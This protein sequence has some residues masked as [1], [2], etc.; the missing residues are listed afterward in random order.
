MSVTRIQKFDQSANDIKMKI[1][2]ESSVGDIPKIIL[3]KAAQFLNWVLA[4]NQTELELNMSE[5]LTVGKVSLSMDK[6]KKSAPLKSLG[7]AFDKL[8]FE[9]H[10]K[11]FNMMQTGPVE[12]IVR[13]IPKPKAS[14]KSAA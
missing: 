14:K 13:A 9:D 4:P 11:L 7:I 12:V 2:V 10:S 6:P 5:Q 3:E 8:S 1:Q